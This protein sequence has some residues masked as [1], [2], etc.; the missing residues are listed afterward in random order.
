MQMTEA[1]ESLANYMK[2]NKLL[3]FIALTFPTESMLFMLGLVW[4]DLH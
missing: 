4:A 2:C 1:D 3:C